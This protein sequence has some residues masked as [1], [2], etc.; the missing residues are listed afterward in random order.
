MGA[1]SWP[2]QPFR[3]DQP[4]KTPR[5]AA[6]I[7][8][9]TVS[10]FASNTVPQS[11]MVRLRARVIRSLSHCELVHHE[12]V[13]RRS[14][15]RSS[16]FLHIFQIKH[17]QGA[18]HR[19]TPDNSNSQ[20]QTATMADDDRDLSWKKPDWTKNT[21][22]KATGKAEKMKAGDLASPITSLPHQK[23]DGTILKAGMD[24]RRQ[25]PTQADRRLGQA[26]Y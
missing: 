4:S 3:V 25:G 11:I 16:H 7:D 8:I 26:D 15:F 24:R 17:T 2:P 9:S 6:Y 12:P 18:P 19:T 1:I 23:E 13:A 20:Q 10:C 14:R 5:F 22:L 21:K